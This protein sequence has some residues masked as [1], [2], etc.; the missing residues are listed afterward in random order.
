ML[1]SHTSIAILRD[2]DPLDYWNA[3]FLSQPDLARFAL[4][5]LALPVSSAECERIFSSAKL[6]IT[7]SRSRLCPDII[8]ANEY[9]RAW[10]GKPEEG[11]QKE[12]GK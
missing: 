7:A 1:S 11:K 5:M 8:E 2:T 4:D 3:R 6:L 10:I 9:L 12:K